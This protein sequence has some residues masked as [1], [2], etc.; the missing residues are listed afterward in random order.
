MRDCL[1]RP[2]NVCPPSGLQIAEALLDDLSVLDGVDSNLVHGHALTCFLW[3]YIHLEAHHELV[4]VDVGAFH[5]AAMNLMV[6]LP[7]LALR[8]DAGLAPADRHRTVHGLVADDVVRI[9]LCGGSLMIVLLEKVGEILGKFESCHV[10]APCSSEEARCGLQGNCI[11][12]PIAEI[13]LQ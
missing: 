1:G 12:P 13:W 9:V 5:R 4:A 3:R 7:P 2:E 10:T 6:R 8:L 11:P